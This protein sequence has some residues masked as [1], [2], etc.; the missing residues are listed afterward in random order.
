MRKIFLLGTML[1]VASAA[2]AFGGVFSHGSKS[3]TY[4]GGVDAIGVHING[5]SNGGADVKLVSCSAYAGTGPQ[6][7]TTYAGGLAGLADDDAT[8]CRCPTGQKWNGSACIDSDGAPC[9]SWTTNECG[10]GYYCYISKVEEIESN[11]PPPLPGICKSSEACDLHVIGDTGY[12][13]AT[14]SE[15]C[16]LNWW[17]AHSI[18]TS[19]NMQIPKVE[20]LGCEGYNYEQEKEQYQHVTCSTENTVYGELNIFEDEIWSANTQL[21]NDDCH[22][23]GTFYY[24]RVYFE[25]SAMYDGAKVLCH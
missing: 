20:D 19:H 24:G 8:Q 12:F 7:D 23:P 14:S 11:C 1:G 25:T 10:S 2:F 16:P 22:T 17:S 18:C 3:T 4:K 13:I 5:K 15:A 21:E 9:S 6:D